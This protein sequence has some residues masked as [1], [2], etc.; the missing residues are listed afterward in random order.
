MPLSIPPASPTGEEV[1]AGREGCIQGELTIV[2][3]ALWFRD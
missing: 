2:A 3:S 1:E